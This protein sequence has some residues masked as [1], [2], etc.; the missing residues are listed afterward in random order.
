MPGMRYQP[1][2]RLRLS[3]RPGSERGFFFAGGEYVNKAVQYER[4]FTAGV[5][6]S[7]GPSGLAMDIASTSAQN[8]LTVASGI[9]FSLQSGGCTLIVVC[10]G[11]TPGAGTSQGFIGPSGSNF[12]GY[13]GSGLPVITIGGTTHVTGPAAISENRTYVLAY[14]YL[15]GQ[16]AKIY[17]DGVLVAS[18]APS[19]VGIDYQPTLFGHV[20]AA[21]THGRH[22]IYG[23]ALFPR[24]VLSDEEVAGLSAS[25]WQLFADP[26]EDD[27]FVLQAATGHSIIVTPASL[28]LGG[29]EVA[30]RVARRIGVQSAALALTGGN[31]ALTA[32][33]K[34]AVQSAALG[35]SAGDV[36]L[37]AARRLAV[38]PASLALQPGEALLRANRRLTVAPVS[39]AVTSGTI[40][41]AYTP[42]PTAGSYVMAITP[43][44]LS[45]TGGNVGMRVTRRVSVAAATLNLSAGDV[46]LLAGYRMTVSP[47]A[48]AMAGG[49]VL[50]RAAR[51]LQIEPAQLAITGGAVT[52]RY[53]EQIEYAR[54]PAGSGYSPQRVEVQSRPAQLGGH[55]PA[56]TQRNNR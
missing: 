36:A 27:D 44:A 11:I 14:S 42:A 12:F 20:Q 34:I 25:L 47:A 9:D 21:S 54:A 49:Q 28:L 18:A 4:A 15:R 17:V 10:E 26:E 29:G 41:F 24:T 22:R 40:Q 3:P 32:S 38:S 7:G 5:V 53:S 50:L 43:A 13:T 8:G 1:Q 2:G 23:A 56:S 37:R 19:A 48:L 45:L 16:I 55:R 6:Q 51:R 35:L 31:V 33:R 30:M 39:M 52:L 46:R